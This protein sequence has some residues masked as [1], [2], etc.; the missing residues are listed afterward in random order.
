MSRTA[1]GVGVVLAL[2]TAIGLGAGTATA[3]A[4]T[5]TISG[6][7]TTAPIL[8]KVYVPVSFTVTC[9]ASPFFNFESGSV[10]IT[11]YV[12]KQIA[13]GTATING[14]ICDSVPHSYTVNVFP[15]T[16]SGFPSTSVSPPFSRGTAVLSAQVNGGSGSATVGP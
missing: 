3:S 11:Q 7:P 5:P 16:G 15:D 1:R 13:H 8:D 2:A 10:T 6:L 14:I 12:H 4:A 9:D